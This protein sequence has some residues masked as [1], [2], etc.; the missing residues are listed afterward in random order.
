[1][2]WLVQRSFVTRKPA[3]PCLSPLVLLLV[4]LTTA[5]TGLSSHQ[6][7]HA[8]PLLLLNLCSDPLLL[9][10]VSSSSIFVTSRR[11]LLSFSHQVPPAS[12]DILHQS[13][14]LHTLTFLVP[15]LQLLEPQA[16]RQVV[17]FSCSCLFLSL[18]VAVSAVLPR[19]HCEGWC[20]CRYAITCRSRWESCPSRALEVGRA[21]CK[22]LNQ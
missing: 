16:G 9:S 1:M 21:F 6:K 11:L 5:C 22:R 10:Y 12:T 7:T 18:C 19:V 14:L 2:R 15:G 4:C 8:N 20:M 13:L 17:A 3:R